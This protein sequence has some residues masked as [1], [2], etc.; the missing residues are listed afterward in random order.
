[1]TADRS[2]S[3]N[4]LRIVMA[5]VLL[6]TR[7]AIA[8]TVIAPVDPP[9]RASFDEQMVARGAQ[10]NAIGNCETCHTSVGGK[11]FAGGRPLKTPFGTVHATNITPDPDT[12]IGQWSESAFRRALHEGVDR[13]GRHL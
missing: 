3:V 10:L 6:L 9:P 1:L 7:P 2:S 4:A 8:A 11:A 5:C 13:L 12:G